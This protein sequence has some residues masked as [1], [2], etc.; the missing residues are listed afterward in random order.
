[1]WG[2]SEVFVH[3]LRAIGQAFAMVGDEVKYL[4][5]YCGH[6]DKPLPWLGKK[7]GEKWDRNQ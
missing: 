6:L 3:L 1:M 5:I 2:R 7:M 4:S